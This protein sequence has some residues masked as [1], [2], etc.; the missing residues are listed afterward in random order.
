MDRPKD[1]TSLDVWDYLVQSTPPYLTREFILAW[2]PEILAAMR[3]D[4]E[5]RQARGEPVR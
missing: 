2:A 5:V 3:L 4:L 1:V